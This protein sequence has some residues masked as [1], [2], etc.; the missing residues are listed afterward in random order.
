MMIYLQ[1]RPFMENGSAV[2]DRQ[3]ARGFNEL[4]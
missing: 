2:T 1:Y 3:A 4:F